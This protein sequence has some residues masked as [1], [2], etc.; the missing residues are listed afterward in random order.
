MKLLYYIPAIG[1]PDLDIKRD[2][3]LHNLNY[4]YNQINEPFDISISFYDTSEEIKLLLSQLTFL[5]NIY[6]YE[7]KG[8]LTE[9]FLTNPKNIYNN[10]YDYII[11]TLDD[12][13]IIN[14]DIYQMIKIKKQHEIIVM[15]PKVLKSNHEFVR[16][17]LPETSLTINNMLEIYLLLLTPSD[18]DIFCK[19]HTIRN[20]WM[21]G[22][23]LLFG[24]YNIK[25]GV[26]YSCVVEQILPSRSDQRTAYHL[27]IEYFKEHT[28]YND[29]CQ[30]FHDYPPIKETINV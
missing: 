20:K 2:I 7:K 23:D 11:F 5:Q 22:V 21:W 3:L 9:L 6:I 18:F 14:L 28:K 26:L 30:I 19:F 16:M 17:E 13:K 8:V 15:S 12:V 25:A 1:Y 24:Y 27:M 4:I 10:K 29:M